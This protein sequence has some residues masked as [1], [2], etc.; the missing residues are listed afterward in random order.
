MAELS[1]FARPYAEAVFRIARDGNSLSEWSALLGDMAS[2]AA[3]PDMAALMSDPT[4][5]TTQLYDVF[6]AATKRSLSPEAQNLLRTLIDN[7][8]LGVLPNIAGQFNE[9]KNA[10]EGAAEA[11]VISAFPLDEAQLKELVTVMEKRF[12]VRLKPHVKVDDSLIGGVRVSV[13]DR[14]LDASV[15]AQLESMQAALSA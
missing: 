9:L 14:T 11:E 5:A 1:T 3:N 8:R 15:R 7:D 10:H 12:G 2:I 6:A 4:V 13:G